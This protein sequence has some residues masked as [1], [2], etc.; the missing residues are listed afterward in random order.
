M[1]GGAV[2]GQFDEFAAI[3]FR[4]RDGFREHSREDTKILFT[5]LG[6]KFNEQVENRSY[7][8]LD[9]TNRNLPGGLTKSEM[10]NDPSQAN[11][12]AIAQDWNKEWSY[13]HLADKLS[14]R[15]GEI[16]FDAG[17]FWFHRD[18]ENRGFFSP[19]FREGIEE[20]YSDNFGGNLNLVS[21]YE[22]FG[23]RNILT[24]GLSPQYET[25]P[26]KTTKI[27]SDTQ[28]QQLREAQAARSISQAISRT[29]CISLRGY[30]SSPERRRFLR[31]GI[32]KMSSCQTKEKIN[33]IGKTFWGFNPK[34]GAIY[35]INRQT[36]AFMN[37]SRSW[38]PPSLD[39]LFDFT[40]DP[41]SSVVYT[42]LQPQHAW[43]IEVGSRGAISRIQRE[44]SLY[45]SCVRNDC[46]RS[47]TPSGM[48]LAQETSRGQII[49]ESRQVWTLTCFGKFWCQRSR[50]AQAIGYH[51][52]KATRSTIIISIR[53]PFTVTI[54]SRE[55]RFMFMRRN[56]FT[57]ALLA[58][59]PG[60][61][62]SVISRVIQ[63]MRRTRSLRIV[64]RCLVSV[65]DFDGPTDS[66]SLS[67]AG[68]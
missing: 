60:Q 53:T 65:R 57:K 59:M 1:S 50:I 26:R 3:G 36:Q 11:P 54:A 5:D 64:M 18:F 48:I 46:S 20:F 14:I 52:T 56:C 61:T 25:N 55:F 43:T 34:L 38:Q 44:L 62:C 40:E 17:V 12:L 45:R 66:Q 8:T 30:R 63:L 41:N 32:S 2:Q 7:L 37:F 49:K 15:T 29:S 28:A 27:F 33:Q 51:S 13:I 23:R 22:L 31:N 47:T 35:A 16:Q 24:I 68:I 6:Y 9:R 4:E 10:D 39:N 58:S 19:N 42:P 21:R 67:I